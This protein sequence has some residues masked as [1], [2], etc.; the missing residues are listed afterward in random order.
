MK[1]KNWTFGVV[2]Y[3]LL[4]FLSGCGDCCSHDHSNLRGHDHKKK[5]LVVVNVLDNDLYA[6]C[7]IKDSINI[8]FEMIE[9]SADTIDKNAQVVFYCSDYQCSSSEW[10]A[11]KFK[12]KG[13]REVYVYEGG[14]A[15][16]YQKGLPTEGPH[17]KSYLRKTVKQVV[18]DE[19]SEIPLISCENLATKMNVAA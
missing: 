5:G 19:Q 6:D 13:F 1:S 17:E 16:W 7:H 10:A 9:T 11:K 14:M 18:S 8:P 12:E 3:G 2:L 15:E 4:L